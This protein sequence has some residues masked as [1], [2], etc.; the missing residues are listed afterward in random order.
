MPTLFPSGLGALGCWH[1][2]EAWAG[3]VPKDGLSWGWRSWGGCARQWSLP[4]GPGVPAPLCRGPQPPD[5]GGPPAVELRLLHPK[6]VGPL[7]WKSFEKPQGLHVSWWWGSHLQPLPWGRPTYG[8]KHSPQSGVAGTG[9]CPGDG[10]EEGTGHRPWVFLL[11]LSPP[12]VQEQAFPW[13]SGAPS[14]QSRAQRHAALCPFPMAA[15]LKPLLVGT[16]RACRAESKKDLP[17]RNV[18]GEVI[19]KIFKTGQDSKKP[20]Q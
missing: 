11:A 4:H 13:G 17:S 5:P 1:I 19:G 15:T 14:D 6:D 3:S 7:G 2:P 18:L 10:E 20:F 12:T 8:W 9:I 16:Y